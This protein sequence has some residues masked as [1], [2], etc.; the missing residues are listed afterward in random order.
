MVN[1]N[2]EETMKNLFLPLILLV[3]VASLS[4][5]GGA[6]KNTDK[7][8]EGTQ[9]KVIQEKTSNQPLQNE[10]ANQ[11]AINSDEK[12]SEIK[13]AG[14][15]TA[16]EEKIADIKKAQTNQN[17]IGVITKSDNAVS[18]AEKEK[19]LK[20]LDSEISGMLKDVESMDEISD[21]DLTE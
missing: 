17:S 18:S 16:G 10:T 8:K 19:V 1:R 21:S 2:K 15:S 4:A 14:K 9:A 20:D 6:A 13:I 7:N 12:A 5:C 11:N 3:T